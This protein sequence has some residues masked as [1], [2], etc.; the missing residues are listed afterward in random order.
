MDKL[1]SN[2]NITERKKKTERNSEKDRNSM[3]ESV[4]EGKEYQKTM[5]TTMRL[6]IL[7]LTQKPSQSMKSYERMKQTWTP[8]TTKRQ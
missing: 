7:L 4:R 1:K 6:V 8:E 2:S 5:H 3:R